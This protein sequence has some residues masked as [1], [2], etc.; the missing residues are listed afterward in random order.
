MGD[1]PE[2]ICPIKEDTYKIQLNSQGLLEAM[3]K[4]RSDLE[5]C[6]ECPNYKSCPVLDNINAS[7][8]NALQEIIDEWGLDQISHS[9][10]V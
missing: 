2:I 9:K 1:R 8:T 6:P 4:L 10:S 7:V 5:S 3:R